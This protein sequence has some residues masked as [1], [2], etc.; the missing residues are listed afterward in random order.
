[1]S[2]VVVDIV[3]GSAVSPAD[4]VTITD[5]ATRAGVTALR[6]LDDGSGHGLDAA[7]VTSYLAGTAAEQSRLGWIVE[8]ST[9][10]NAPY[11]LARRVQSIDRATAGRA[12]LSLRAGD[13]DEV[14]D[15]V[16]PTAATDRNARWAEYA[17][18]V[19]RLWGSFPRAALLGDQDA[20]IFAD[21]TRIRP[22]D[23]DGEYYRVAGPLDGPASPQGRPLLVADALDAVGWDHVARYADVVVVGLAAAGGADAELTAALAQLGRRRQEVALLARVDVAD[24]AAAAEELPE[25][26]AAHRLDGVELVVAGGRDDIVEVLSALAP[27]LAPRTGATLR[28]AFGLPALEVA[29]A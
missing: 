25:L 13:G 2:I 4:A 16:A 9:S 21:D 19:T 22:I 1:M 27:A 23:V 20:G 29:I 14:S 28:E 5:A 10:R 26:I 7:V 6:V 8:A 11:N 18:I 12:G 24:P 3:V 17:R 15:P